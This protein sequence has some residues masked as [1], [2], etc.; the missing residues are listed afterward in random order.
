MKKHF[1]KL[2]HMAHYGIPIL[3]LGIQIKT[4]QYMVRFRGI[5]E[6]P[7]IQISVPSVGTQLFY[8]LEP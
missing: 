7:M 6:N 2:S 3:G 1:H 5:G 4:S 8:L